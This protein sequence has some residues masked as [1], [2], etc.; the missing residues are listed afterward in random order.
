[1]YFDLKTTEEIIKR[2][3]QKYGKFEASYIVRL[4]KNKIIERGK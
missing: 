3:R 4:L 2:L 1:L